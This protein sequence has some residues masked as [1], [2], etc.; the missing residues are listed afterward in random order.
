MNGGG[1]KREMKQIAFCRIV[2]TLQVGVPD[3]R[4]DIP[5][6]DWTFSY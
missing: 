2:Q 6:S 1:L 3:A 5:V 4:L